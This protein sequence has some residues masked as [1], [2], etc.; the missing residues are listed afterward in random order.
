MPSKRTLA[1]V[2]I[3]RVQQRIILI[4]GERVNLASEL[5]KLYG[6]STKRLNEAVKRNLAR[7][8]EDFMFQLTWDEAEN[9]KSRIATLNGEARDSSRS[10]IATL[11]RGKNFKYRPHAFTEHGAI[12]AAT[13]LNSP[14]AVNASLFVVRAFVQL[15]ELL[16]TH[17]QL[18]FKLAELEQRLETHDGQIIALI[19][20]I[21][22]LM[23]EPDDPPKPPIGF[24]TELD[25]P[26]Q[27]RAR[28]L[29]PA[30]N[31]KSARTPNP[32]TLTR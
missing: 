30:G 25:G 2:P 5:G 27:T 18:A 13:V 24:Q 23:T 28:R 32:K 11:N 12:M 19:D 29:K 22:E 26:K 9:L 14:Q 15:R 16:S 20:A 21:R 1:L 3:D 4:R 31:A 8:P 7:F 10:Q 6:V 17:T